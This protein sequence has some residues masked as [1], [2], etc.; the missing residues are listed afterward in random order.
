M[1]Y[2]TQL[3]LYPR[4]GHLPDRLCYSLG[5]WIARHNEREN[6]EDLRI[7]EQGL[8]RL[9]PESKGDTEYLLKQRYSRARMMV[10]DH[11]DC[12]RMASFK[13]DKAPPLVTLEGAEHLD[14][15][16]QAGHGAILLISHFGRFFM[17]GPGL[18]LNGHPFAMLTTRVDESNPAYADPAVLNYWQQKMRNTLHHSRFEWLTTGNNYRK[19]FQVLKQNK[20]LLIALDGTETDSS[21]RIEIPF[22]NTQLSLPAGTIRIAERSK[23][24]IV[25]AAVYNHSTSPNVHIMIRPLSTD[26]TAALHE[27]VSTLESDIRKTPWQWWQWPALGTLCPDLAHP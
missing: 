25:Y 23:A 6:S 21:E 9:I 8:T 2:T 14:N 13:T 12:Y 3:A 7:F 22:F 18:G 17:L 24:P 11:L 4:L 15:A 27:A 16:L 20:P 26:P 10:F 5:E 19:I 1:R